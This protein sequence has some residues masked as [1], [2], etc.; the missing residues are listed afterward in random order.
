MKDAFYIEELG[1]VTYVENT[2]IG[3]KRIL[4]NGM[5]LVKSDKYIYTGFIDGKF[6][7][8]TLYGNILRGCKLYVRDYEIKIIRSPYWYEWI[9]GFLSFLL[10]IIMI[11][12]NATNRLA[13]INVIYYVSSCITCGIAYLISYYAVIYIRSIKKLY[14]KVLLGIGILIIS[15]LITVFI[16]EI[17]YLLFD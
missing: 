3:K 13:T 9:L 1:E 4:I 11:I 5:P 10:A 16:W 14:L 12:F 15:F 8:A 17:S 2:F 6:I 7:K